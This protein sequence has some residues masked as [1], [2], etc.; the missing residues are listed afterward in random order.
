MRQSLGASAAY[1]ACCSI[2]ARWRRQASRPARARRSGQAVVEAAI[3]TMMSVVTII[4]ILQ[5]SLVVAQVIGASHVARA[6]S[7]WLAVRVDTIDSDVV[8]QANAYAN[9]LPGISNGGISSVTVSP[10]CT[11]LTAGKCASRSS[12]DAVTVT[13]TANLA[14]VMFLPTTWGIAPLQF[15]LPATMPPIAY[16]VLLE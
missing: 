15:R 2:A 12:G 16:T 4:V 1:R 11:A 5:L 8:T 3:T 10:A 13:V 9:N 6:T 7:R 14:R